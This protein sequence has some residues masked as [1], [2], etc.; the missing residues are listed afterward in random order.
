MDETRA[1]DHAGRDRGAGEAAPAGE[2]RLAALVLALQAVGLAVV[3][4]V[5]LV[6]TLTGAP[7]DVA[8]ALFAVVFALGGAALL[9]L[10]ARWLLRLRTGLRTPVIVLE[11]LALPVGYSLG[12]QAGR[13]GYGAPILVSALAVL[14]LLFTP[15][16]R[17]Q[18]DA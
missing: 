10:S 4:G 17:A 12:F 13:M 11:L 3:A 6:K 9:L 8:G 2:I 18:L 5:L 16:V 7:R 15:A 1:G 14:Y